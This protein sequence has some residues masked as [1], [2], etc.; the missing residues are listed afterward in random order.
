MNHFAAYSVPV[1]GGFWAMCRFAQNARPWPIMDGDRPKIFAVRSAAI[2]AAQ[3]HVIKHINGTM[4]RDG[5]K[6]D[7]AKCKAERLFRKGG[8]VIPVERIGA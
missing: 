2:I 7:A 1:P 4:R 8:K 6:I 5:E 3:D